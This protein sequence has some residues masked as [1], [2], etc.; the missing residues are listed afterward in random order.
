VLEE[1]KPVPTSRRSAK[2]WLTSAAVVALLVAIVVYVS[3]SEELE[4]VRRLS[5]QVLVATVVLQ[6]VSQVFLNFSLLLPLQASVTRL[7]FWELYLV[8]TG[9]LVVGSLMP[10]AGGLAVRLAY[11]RSRGLTYLDFMW[12]TSLSNVL[13]LA[14]AAVVAVG[15]TAVVWSLAGRPPTPVLLALAIVLAMSVAAVAV[16]EYLPRITNHPRFAR[17]QWLSSM[18]SLRTTRPMAVRVFVL[19]LV[20]HGLNF[21]TFG[22]L[23]RA[24]SGA[25][26]DFVT[27]GLLY[28]LTSPVRMVN[29]TPGN[30]GITEWVVA[31]VGKMLAYN[32][33]TGLIVAVAFRAIAL[34]AQALGAGL[35]SAWLAVTARRDTA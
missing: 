35:G 19:C 17:W 33:T 28:A 13:A 15:A 30:L 32:L 20:R 16:F 6:F 9:G 8:R 31:A 24:L 2:D 26:G 10:V 18:S 3:R 1:P 27:G 34:V 7:G 29:I 12:A 25:P 23:T 14:A 4:S 11:L 22:V 21:V 5:V